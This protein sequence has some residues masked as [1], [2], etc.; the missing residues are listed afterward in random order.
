MK[1]T[2]TE[3]YKKMRFY[4]DKRLIKG[5]QILCIRCVKNE[6]TCIQIGSHIAI[7]HCEACRNEVKKKFGGVRLGGYPEFTTEKIKQERK[8]YWNSQVQPTREGDISK[9]FVEVYPEKA[10]KMFG[11][12]A[13]KAKYVWNDTAGWSHRQKSK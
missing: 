7:S 12:D 6:A 2:V 13:A 3:F 5:D 8:E 4:P 10:R 9:E 11:S 1:L